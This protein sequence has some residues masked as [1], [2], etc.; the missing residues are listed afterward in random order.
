MNES[1]VRQAIFPFY[2]SLFFYDSL[3][4]FIIDSSACV[5]GAFTSLTFTP[6]VSAFWYGCWCFHCRFF[7][8][9]VC[10]IFHSFLFVSFDVIALTTTSPVTD[11]FLAC[12]VC[13]GIFRGV[14]FLAN[15]FMLMYFSFFFLFTFHG[16]NHPLYI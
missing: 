9:F 5:C 15:R 12:R 2:D 6:S 1:V 14:P 11:R 3:P 8:L 10:F 13:F 7:S 4:T 16:Y